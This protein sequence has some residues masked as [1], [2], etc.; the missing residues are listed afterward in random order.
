MKIFLTGA[1]GVIGRRLVPM[2]LE[3]GHDVTAVGRTPERRA[4]LARAGASPVDVNLFDTEAVRAAVDGHDVV[5]NLAT[6]I[7]PVSRVF[8]P[9]A[10]NENDRLRREAS[11]NLVDAS[12]A[13]GA[14]RFIQESFAPIYAAGGDR[15]LTEDAP[16]Q[17]APHTRTALDAEHAAERFGREGGA[18]VVLRFALFYGADS[19]PTRNMIQSVRKGWAPMFGPPEGY[20]SSVSHDDAATAVVAALGIPSGIYNVVDDEPLM[21]RAHLDALADILGVTPPR[22]LPAWLARV[23]GSVGNMLSRSHRMSNRKLRAHS[24]WQPRFP[25]VREGWK[26]VVEELQTVGV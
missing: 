26:A 21:R 17:P 5:V 2:L 25:S 11:A 15:W 24:D 14:S 7:P 19:E 1:T 20:V 13:T 9:G 16:V 23:T 6:R 10:W 4:E 3:A 22:L 8:L 12:L 18:G